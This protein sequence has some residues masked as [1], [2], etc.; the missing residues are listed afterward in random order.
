MPQWSY[1]NTAQGMNTYE[2]NALAMTALIEI[3]K[4]RATAQQLALQA[5]ALVAEARDTGSSWSQIGEALGI[6]KQA[7]IQRYGR[8]AK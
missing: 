3:G 4:A 2:R 5:P 1:A 7:A 8:P 6:S